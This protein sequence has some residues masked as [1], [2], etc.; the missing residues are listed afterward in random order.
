[1]LPKA[2]TRQL[3]LG[4]FQK[5]RGFF[6]IGTTVCNPEEGFNE[7][8]TTWHNI[9]WRPMVST[10][11]GTQTEHA[12]HV[13]PLNKIT[14]PLF[15]L[16]IIWVGNGIPA[17]LK[18]R[19]LFRI[20]W[21]E[22]AT[23]GAR[24]RS[25]MIHWKLIH[26]KSMVDGQMKDAEVLWSSGAMSPSHSNLVKVLFFEL[27]NAALERLELWEFWMVYFWNIFS[28]CDCLWILK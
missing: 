1:M 13:S 6:W 10:S 9:H 20:Q 22:S 3:G 8:H 25:E 15:E 16:D 17:C 4:L 12:E 18:A 2:K 27:A 24:C 11:K 7:W 26:E 14:K 23:A 5:N 28:L 21:R 19:I